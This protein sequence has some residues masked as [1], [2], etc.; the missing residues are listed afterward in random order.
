MKPI[1][2]K[3]ADDM[4]YERWLTYMGLKLITLDLTETHCIS[5]RSNN[6]SWL[7]PHGL[8]L[9]KHLQLKISHLKK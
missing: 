3:E 7:I 1:R 5:K 4:P 2:I 9:E 8:D 6:E